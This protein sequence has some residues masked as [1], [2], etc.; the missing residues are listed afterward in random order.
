MARPTKL[1]PEVQAKLLEAIRVGASLASACD[2][3]GVD[4]SNFRKWMIR[5][6]KEK[7]GKYREFHE[8]VRLGQGRL[9]LE[10][11][12]AWRSHCKDD[13]RAAAEFLARRFPDRWS[14]TL[15]LQA[16]LQVEMQQHIEN[17]FN[18]FFEALMDD[19][20][21]SIE[22]KKRVLDIAA[23]QNTAAKIGAEAN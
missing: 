9:E 22:Q 20:V 5:G 23:S 1:T 8:A 7:C 18:C 2:Y 6:E 16:K 14:P 12:I 3:A 17:E 4:Y 19:D 10:M 15:Q 11:V 21:L 13:W